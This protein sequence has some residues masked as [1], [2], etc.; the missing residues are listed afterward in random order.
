MQLRQNPALGSL[1]G[2]FGVV[3]KN[4]K[5]LALPTVI[6]I[7]V[8]LFL[9]GIALL[10]VSSADV[11]HAYVQHNNT[12]AHYLARSGAHVGLEMMENRLNAGNYQNLDD[13][14]TDLN[15][16][17]ATINPVAV[18]QFGNFNLNYERYSNR[19]VKIFST[20]IRTSTPVSSDM[21][22]LRVKVIVPATPDNYPEGWYSGINLKKGITTTS[23]FLGQG[24]LLEGNPTSSPMGS[25]SSSI[26]QASIFY[27]TENIKKNSPSDSYISL[28]Q[29]NNTIPITFDGEI[30]YFVGRITLNGGSDP[31]YLSLSEAAA[32]DKL[33]NPSSILYVTDDSVRSIL[34]TDG[35]GFENNVYY[36]YVRQGH[37][38]DY[39]YAFTP[40]TRYG[41]AYFGGN[42]YSSSGTTLLPS[43][44]KYYFFPS[45]VNLKD[46]NLTSLLIP[47][48]PDDGI[49]KALENMFKFSGTEHYLWDKE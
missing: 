10:N 31:I 39:T 42:I 41:V 32:M 15:I 17:A 48:N 49:I 7:M 40:G 29:I 30:I 20:G 35:V 2:G 23:S 8:V 46:I 22:T 1:K 11:T 36:Q 44:N 26:F 28:R 25:A 13:L 24:V 5:G 27:F 43:G 4:N 16:E 37:P 3:I 19:E 47:I 38:Q 6:M 33:T 14:V 9:L 18:P 45:G 34:G 12:Q 21:V